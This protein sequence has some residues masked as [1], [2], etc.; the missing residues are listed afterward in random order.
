MTRPRFPI[1]RIQ[2]DRGGEFFARSVQHA[3][4]AAG[5]KFRPTRPAAP[6][7]NGKVERWQRT[8]KDELWARLDVRSLTLQQA[9]DEGGC[10][11]FF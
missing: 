8:D 3:Y 7:L 1:Q 5:I 4:M 10:W 2:T 11:A 9:S 6:H